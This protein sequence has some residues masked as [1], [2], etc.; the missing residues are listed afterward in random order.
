MTIRETEV[1]H[2][3][4]LET[5]LA[6]FG[7]QPT[8]TEVG[9]LLRY[10]AEL[11]R[12]NGTVNLTALKGAVLIRRLVIEPLW[13]L[14]QLSPTGRYLDIGS[15][16]G[17][18]AVPWHIRGQFAEVALVE[19]RRRR[20]TFLRQTTRQLGLDR[21]R[22]H[23]GRFEDVVMDLRPADWITLQGVRLTVPLLEKIGS[24]SAR[25]ATAVWLTKGAHPALS[26]T[27]VLEIPFSDRRALIFEL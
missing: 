9:K 11:E 26:P 27:G 3:R 22:V 2:A 4:A 16:N 10:A 17:S 6:E 8:D 25:P 15:G 18:P 24:N 19:A 13:V 21:V 20:A 5:Q 14:G 12:W 7:L 23:C 1:S